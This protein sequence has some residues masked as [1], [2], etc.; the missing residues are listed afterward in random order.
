M[1][2]DFF[3]FLKAI[4]FPA[5]AEVLCVHLGHPF[6]VQAVSLHF[7]F[8]IYCLI[9]RDSRSTRGENLYPSQVFPSHSHCPGHM[10]SFLHAWPSTFSKICRRFSKSPADISFPSRFWYSFLFAPAITAALDRVM[11]NNFNLQFPPR[12]KKSCFH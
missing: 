10:H 6:N 4:S 3:K 9:H 7:C 12:G 2:R 5:F 8:S 11:L 1:D